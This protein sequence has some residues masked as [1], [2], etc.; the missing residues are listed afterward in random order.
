M[1]LIYLFV[2]FLGA[3]LGSFLNVVALRWNSG[4]G[5]NGRSMCVAC[6]K[7][8]RW[9]ELIP[10][11][12][13]IL[14]RGKCR[15]CKVALSPRYLLAEIFTGIVFL[16]TFANFIKNGTSD[17]L[18]LLILIFVLAIFCIYIVILMY[19]LQHKII[20]DALVYTSTILAII[21]RIIV[22][23]TLL[24][25]FAG[26]IIFLF[27]YLIW[28]IS[29]GRA[30]GFGDAKLGLSLGIFLGAANGFSG[31]ILAFWIGTIISLGIITVSA[32]G[33][34]LWRRS[35]KLTMKS[36]VPFA[37]FLII[38]AWIAYVWNLDLFNVFIFL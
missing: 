36:E 34:P 33:F 19:D 37:P 31:I 30:M 21:Y 4:F 14:Q 8:L 28:L 12:S 29:R 20:P 15:G 7:T 5:L 17:T 18:S 11:L 16:N 38:G 2:F 22:G 6:G 35:K 1:V 13:F 9:F 10:L 26:P 27:F 3:I 25:F 23:G 24:D 32:L